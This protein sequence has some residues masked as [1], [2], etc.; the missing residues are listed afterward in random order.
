MNMRNYKIKGFTVVELMLSVVLAAVLLAMAGPSL[1]GFYSRL[2]LRSAVSTLETGY[3]YARALAITR[4]S[5]VAYCGSSDGQSCDGQWN[6]KRL[7]V[8][9][10]TGQVLRV[11]NPIGPVFRL[12]WK[13][14][15]GINTALVFLPTGFT[16]GQ[17]GRF[18]ITAKDG[19]IAESATLVVSRSGRMR[20]A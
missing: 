17:Q 6:N 20:R 2:Q 14:G 8:D 3:D 9:M 7:V 4:Q 12:N 18:K 16:N 11:F 13:G 1:R 19:R 10:A 5:K 15:F